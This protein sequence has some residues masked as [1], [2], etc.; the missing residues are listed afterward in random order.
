MQ[1]K[2]KK[3]KHLDE[4]PATRIAAAG[5]RLSVFPCGKPTPPALSPRLRIRVAALQ[6]HLARGWLLAACESPDRRAG[7]CYEAGVCAFVRVRVLFLRA[8]SRSAQALGAQP[9]SAEWTHKKAQVC[10]GAAGQALPAGAGEHARNGFAPGQASCRR[11]TLARTAHGQGTAR[12][13]I[14]YLHR[15]D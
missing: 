15:Y 2:K 14:D 1:K 8:S 3:S 10:Q 7:P 13:L 11:P 9:A 6:T 5:K 4:A 12:T